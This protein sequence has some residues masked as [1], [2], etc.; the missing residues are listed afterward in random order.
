MGP[1]MLNPHGALRHPLE[2][3]CLHMVSTRT[4]QAVHWER[5]AGE[6]EGHSKIPGKV[7]SV[8]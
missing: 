7:V 2:D 4:N 1:T 8:D 5:Q 6:T 3:Q